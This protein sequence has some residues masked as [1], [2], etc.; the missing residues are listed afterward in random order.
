MSSIPEVVHVTQQVGVE[1]PA[2][3]LRARITRRGKSVS[4]DELEELDLATVHRELS[5][6]RRWFEA[7]LDK[8]D[9]RPPIPVELGTIANVLPLGPEGAGYALWRTP[10]SVTLVGRFVLRPLQPDSAA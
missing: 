10:N 4:V 9:K 2:G 3:D 6:L 8:R 5:T 1:V 7:E